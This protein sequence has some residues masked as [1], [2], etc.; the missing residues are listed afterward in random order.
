MSQFFCFMYIR[1]GF[2]KFFDVVIG[3]G[4]ID[5]SPCKVG[6]YFYSLVIVRLGFTKIIFFIIILKL[7]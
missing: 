4:S 5:I 6:V 7:S 3:N 1:P 2:I